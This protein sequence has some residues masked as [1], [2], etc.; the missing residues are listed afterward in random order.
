MGVSIVPKVYLHFFTI[1]LFLRYHVLLRGRY[2]SSDV[3]SGALQVQT[4]AC[5]GPWQS[6]YTNTLFPDLA[7]SLILS[8]YHELYI[9]RYEGI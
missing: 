1:Y 2:S 5:L 9:C 3:T 6:W 8:A 7:L 4:P